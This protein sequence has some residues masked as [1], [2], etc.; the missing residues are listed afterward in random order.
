MFGDT[1]VAAVIVEVVVGLISGLG[2]P[3]SRPY[4][5]ER[6]QGVTDAGSAAISP[7]AGGEPS[8]RRSGPVGVARALPG[9]R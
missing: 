8:K 3:G 1:I 4:R 9:G 6:G 2:V 7:H 5:L